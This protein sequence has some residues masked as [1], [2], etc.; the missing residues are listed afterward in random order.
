MS[1]P[2][3]RRIL[4]KAHGLMRAMVDEIRRTRNALLGHPV[5]YA[6]PKSSATKY[7]VVTMGR[8]PGLYYNYHEAHGQIHEYPHN[9]YKVFKNLIRA[10]GYQS[11]KAT[12]HDA[13]LIA[14]AHV[15]RC[16]LRSGCRAHS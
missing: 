12:E 8:V 7:Y 6:S 1:V 14:A 15:S 13:D 10:L 5:Y 11:V 9:S 3:A 16:V 4:V 2:Q